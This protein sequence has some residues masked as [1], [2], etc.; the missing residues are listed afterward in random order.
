MKIYILLCLLILFTNLNAQYESLLYK[1]YAQ[2]A[3]KMHYFFDSILRFN[4]INK[5]R[6][7]AA[8][9]RTLAINHNDKSLKYEVDLFELFV[10]SVFYSK[11]KNESI[12]AYIELIDIAEREAVWHTKLNATRAL[13]EYYWKF[14]NNYELAFEQF[15][16]LDKAL[17]FIRPEDYPQ[18]ARDYMQIG[19]SYYYFK[20]YN[21]AKKYLLKSINIPETSFNTLVITSAKN[22]LGLCYQHEGNYDSSNYYFQQILS[23]KFKKSLQSWE[24]IVRGNIGG[25][26]YLQGNYTKAI[27][28]LLYD[29]KGAFQ[30][31]DNGS[32][33]GAATSLAD[34]YLQKF[35]LKK[36]KEYIKIARTYIS[37]SGQVD[38]LRGLFPVMSNW[39]GATGNVQLSRKYL[40]STILA[41]NKYNE[42]FNALKVV[43]A[44]QKISHQKELLLKANFRI[45]EQEKINQRNLL[46][47]ISISLVIIIILGY[48]FQ[49]RRRQAIEIEKL[50]IEKELRN[51]KSK[52]EQFVLKINEQNNLVEKINTELTSLKNSESQERKVLEKAIVD[53]R[54]VTI[55]T[56]N[57]WIQFKQHFATI[58]PSFF[59]RLNKVQPAITDSEMRYLML[60]KLQLSHK[61][62]ANALGISPDSVRVTWN[63]VRKKMGG[64]LEDNPIA[65]LDKLTSPQ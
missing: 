15:L 42:E 37:K 12:K 30:S 20:D 49:K 23:T 55:L 60:T 58:Y 63:R 22:T 10:S 26:Y 46:I 18:M 40:D 62:M 35:D 3:D 5:I 25:N 8:K 31:N 53:L 1:T 33:A 38:R 19:E 56:D 39:Y 14:L 16:I 59:M 45:E 11:P 65:L 28:L 21:Q 54:N 50:R 4:D 9:I 17:K 13:A 34:I 2:K 6:S 57:D 27:P 32:I 43:R 52:I 64:S 48:S 24:R 51:S 47:F 36:S 44:Q 61:E 7:E 41:I 29:L